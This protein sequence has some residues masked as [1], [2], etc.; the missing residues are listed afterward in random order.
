MQLK[1]V[2]L[3]FAC[4]AN[5]AAIEENIALQWLNSSWCQWGITAS[6]LAATVWLFDEYIDLPRVRIKPTKKRKRCTQQ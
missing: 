1:S 3:P 4:D 5:E 2:C 6:I